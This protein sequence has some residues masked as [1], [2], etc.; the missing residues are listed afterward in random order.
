VSGNYNLTSEAI[1][2]A[3]LVQIKIAG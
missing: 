2:V 1:S 3:K